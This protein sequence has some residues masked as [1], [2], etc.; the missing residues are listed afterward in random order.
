MTMLQLAMTILVALAVLG[1][2]VAAFRRAGPSELNR[3]VEAL[4]GR[5][6]LLT[7]AADRQAL[8]DRALHDGLS[9][10]RRAV[11]ELRIREQERR[12]RDEESRGALRRLEATFLGAASRGRT[13]ENVVWE[14]LSVLPPDMVDTSFRVNGKTVEFSLRL[15]DGRRLPVDSKWAGVPE[16]EALESAEGPERQQRAQAVERVVAHRAREVA[17]YLDPS[18]TTPFAVAAV[19]D[20]AYAVLRRAHLEAFHHQVLLVPYSGALAVLLALYALCCRLGA[21]ADLGGVVLETEAAIDAIERAL[22]NRVERAATLAQGA[23]SEIRV[24]LGRARGAL[25]RGRSGSGADAEVRAE[26]AS[27][28]RRRSGGYA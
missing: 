12:D 17:K 18:A 11:E 26:V 1:L 22:E 20:A 16:L 9:V 24:Q 13:G 3:A 8:D 7:R 28:E 5:M 19:P 23:A 10:T 15:P 4:A 21:D 2:L 25:A 14:A 27:L 6:D